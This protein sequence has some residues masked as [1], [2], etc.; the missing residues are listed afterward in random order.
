MT[1]LPLKSVADPRCI[2]GARPQSHLVYFHS[3]FLPVVLI[4]WTPPPLKIL[5]PP[6]E[7]VFNSANFPTWHY[8][9]LATYSLYPARREERSRICLSF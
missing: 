7:I 5:D 8:T 1:F 4:G 6:L 2:G 9:Y 3:P